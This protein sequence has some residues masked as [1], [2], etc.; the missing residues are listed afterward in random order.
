MPNFILFLIC[1]HFLYLQS[2]AHLRFK[3]QVQSYLNILLHTS[4]IFTETFTLMFIF[5]LIIHIL[6]KENEDTQA[7]HSS[8]Q[9]KAFN[10]W[11]LYSRVTPQLVEI[12]SPDPSLSLIPEVVAG[13]SSLT[14]KLRLNHVVCSKQAPAICAQDSTSC[15]RRKGNKLGNNFFKKHTQLSTCKTHSCYP[16]LRFRILI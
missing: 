1:D 9:F 5:H 3:V 10:W 2:F 6:L 14:A 8:L 4:L 11:K 13:S 7:Q 12:N 16:S 15:K